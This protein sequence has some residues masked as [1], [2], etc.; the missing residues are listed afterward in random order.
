MFLPNLFQKVVRVC[1]MNACCILG[2]SKSPEAAVRRSQVY[3]PTQ[4]GAV[5]SCSLV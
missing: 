3:I 4:A 1:D 2:P 5:V